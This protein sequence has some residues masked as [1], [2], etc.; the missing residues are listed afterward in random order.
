MGRTAI[1]SNGGGGKREEAE[2][3]QRCPTEAAKRESQWDGVE[4]IGQGEG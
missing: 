1:D 4:R 3:I 2:E